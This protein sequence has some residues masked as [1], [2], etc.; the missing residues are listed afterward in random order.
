MYR[1]IFKR[2]ESLHNK[3]LKGF[4]I[5]RSWRSGFFFFKFLDNKMVIY[6]MYR[7]IFIGKESL[8]NKSLIGLKILGS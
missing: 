5:L 8:H 1:C 2:K 3:S 6:F 7:C 4:K